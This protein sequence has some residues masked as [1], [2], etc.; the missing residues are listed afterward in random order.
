MEN[1]LV[2]PSPNKYIGRRRPL[3]LIVWHSTESSEVKSG[4]YNVAANWFAKVT[5][6]VSAH[7][8]V[9]AGQDPRYASGVIECVYPWD[10]AWHCGNA[11]ADGYGVEIVGRASQTGVEWQDPYSLAA[12]RNACK[13]L[14]WNDQLHHIPARWLTNGELAGGAAGHVTHAQVAKVLGGTT[15]TDPGVNF[16]F[17][18][19]MQL[20]NEGAPEP[21]ADPSLTYGMRNH[22]VVARVQSFLNRRYSYARNLPATGNYLDMTM[23]VVKEFQARTGVAGSDA[24]GRVIGPRTWA[25]L[26]REGYK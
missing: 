3:R 25:A 26:R 22:P 4:A 20:M 24:D 14:K 6:R 12:I 23:R 7:V 16:P 17:D 1:Y 11:N 15:H 9:D 5:S 2:I 18:L 10:T 13:W 21:P 8:V 19:V